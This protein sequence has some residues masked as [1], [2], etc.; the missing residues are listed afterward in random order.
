MTQK[1]LKIAKNWF[2][3]QIPWDW[4]PMAWDREMGWNTMRFFSPPW[5]MACMSTTVKNLLW[6]F[7]KH[8]THWL[9]NSVLFPA[10]LSFFEAARFSC[11]SL[12]LLDLAGLIFKHKLLFSS[13]LTEEEV[14]A[15]FC[16]D[17]VSVGVSICVPFPLST[18]LVWIHDILWNNECILTNFVRIYHR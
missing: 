8:D 15:Y 17:L 6:Q 1:L 3:F 13:P 10:F 12:R 7:D 18:P 5:E 2:L 11:R 14:G 4:H 16:A 9:Q